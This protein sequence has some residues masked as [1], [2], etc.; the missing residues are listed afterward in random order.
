MYAIYIVTF[1]INIPQMLAY[2]YHTW[3]LWVLNT[4]HI[5]VRI[6]IKS[7]EPLIHFHSLGF[8]WM[9]FANY[10]VQLV[11][12]PGLHCDSRLQHLSWNQDQFCSPEYWASYKSVSHPIY[13]MYI[14]MCN[15]NLYIYPLVN[16]QTT[17]GNHHA[18]NGKNS[19]FLWPCS[20]AN[21]TRGYIRLI[22]HWITIKS[23]KITI[24]SIQI[25]LNHHFDHC[26]PTTK[27]P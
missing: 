1:T 14:P 15:Q 16:I 10:N 4:Y 19:L 18:I 13:G 12:A 23:H 27:G 6:P 5:V 20:I 22:S 7:E 8:V 9:F 26:Y 21:F 24:N 2:I 17:M 25:P 11:L 3:I